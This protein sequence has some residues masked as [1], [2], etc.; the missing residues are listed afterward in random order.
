MPTP[1]PSRLIRDTH[2]YIQELVEAGMPRA[3]AET[4]VRHHARLFQLNLAT[5]AEIAQLNATLKT[6]TANLKTDTTNLKTEP[7]PE[8]AENDV[9]MRPNTAL[10][11]I[12][13]LAS[14]V[15]PETGEILPTDNIYQRP[16]TIRALGVAVV[17]LKQYTDRQ[18]RQKPKPSSAGLTWA[19][20]EDQRL[21]TAYDN[22]TPISKLAKDHERTRAG[23]KARL[24]RHGR[25]ELHKP[26]MTKKQMAKIHKQITEMCG[27]TDDLKDI[28][29]AAK[30]L[31]I[32]VPPD[33]AA[34]YD[35]HQQQI[36][37]QDIGH[38]EGETD[39]PPQDKFS[40]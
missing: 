22:G 25:I 10:D 27:N 5:K 18:N 36:R 3:Q 8:T 1:Q 34:T 37:E 20:S 16:D 19:E 13:A 12:S 33:A 31:G 9:S 30:T 32:D 14:N 39:A 4:I 38:S 11:I 24:N 17:A 15:D 28:A 23:I 40:L 26:S 7:N 35:K 21:L 2:A 6:D 29:W